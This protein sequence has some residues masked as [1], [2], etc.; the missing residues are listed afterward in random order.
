MSRSTVGYIA[1]SGHDSSAPDRQ[2]CD[3]HDCSHVYDGP[4]DD[5]YGMMMPTAK[6]CDEYVQ[7]CHTMAILTPLGQILS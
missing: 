5:G 6:R 1:A 4:D 2:R 3:R 7:L